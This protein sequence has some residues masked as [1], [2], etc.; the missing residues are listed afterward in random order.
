MLNLSFMISLL[1]WATCPPYIDFLV[2]L[3][4]GE[5]WSHTVAPLLLSF[6]GVYLLLI[7]INGLVEALRDAVSSPEKIQAQAPYMIGFIVFYFILGSIL[8]YVWGAGGLILAACTS[9]LLRCFFTLNYFHKEMLPL[10]DGFPSLDV[11]IVYGFIF[12][13]ANIAKYFVG[14]YSWYLLPVGG[15][16]AFLLFLWFYFFKFQSFLMVFDE[17][18]ILDSLSNFFIFF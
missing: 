1:Y 11:W 18:K 4:F 16:Q 9:T 3:I 12:I 7:G 13:S 5:K 10:S 14:K 2:H 17:K 15:L 8:M 6:Y